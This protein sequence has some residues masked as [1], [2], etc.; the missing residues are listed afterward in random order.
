MVMGKGE[1]LSER[2]RV[3]RHKREHLLTAGNEAYPAATARNRTFTEIRTPHA[4]LPPGGRFGEDV[5]AAGRVMPQRDIG[6][7][8]FA[9][10]RDGDAELQVLLAQARAGEVGELAGW[11]QCSDL[12][13]IVAVRRSRT[14]RSRWRG[15]S[16]H[17]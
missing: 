12:A 10:S 8:L 7:I 17:R 13:D 15:S 1:S 5:E 2:T 14:V 6:G 3:R 11:R 16:A 4:D 9:T